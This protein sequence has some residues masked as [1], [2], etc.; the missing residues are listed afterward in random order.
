[1]KAS[2]LDQAMA[3]ET[4]DAAWRKLRREHTPWSIHVSREQLQQHLLKH[5]LE[6]RS[7]V[8]SGRYRPQPL[9]QFPLQKPDGKQRVLSAQY[10]KDK[11][12][13]RA[14]LT[15]LEPR[16]EAIFHDDSFAYRPGRSVAMALAKVRERVRIGQAWLVDADISKFFDTIPHRQLV[17]L[18][19]GFINDSQAMQLIEKWLSQGAHYRSLLRSPRGISQGAILSPLFCNLYLHTFDMALTKANIPFVRFADDFLLFSRVKKDAIK[20]MHFA[21][22]VLEE[23]GLE[24]HP[25]K[26]R[27]VRSGKS[28]VFLGE[29]LPDP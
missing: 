7:Q 27:I 2:L 9:R 29:R 15:V 26:T 22:E 18:L 21:K 12:V 3:P 16:S 6:C 13:Q 20:A 24:L 1:M 25:G 8:L 5:I 4:L 23:L 28:V 14:L 17:K 19:K 10:L 11:F